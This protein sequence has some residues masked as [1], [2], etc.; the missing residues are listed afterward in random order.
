MFLEFYHALAKIACTHAPNGVVYHAMSYHITISGIEV[1]CDT[2]EEVMSLL[3]LSKPKGPGRPPKHGQPIRAIKEIADLHKT[4]KFLKLL[5]ECGQSGAAASQIVDRLSLNGARGIGGALV[6]VRKVLL[7]FNFNPSE[8]FKMIGFRSD[9][10]WKRGTKA[11]EA[12]I[13][14]EGSLVV[15]K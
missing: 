10:R 6:A 5:I 13:L 8:V 7:G 2:P 11:E 14:V 3:G 15:K 9:R 12:L 4:H 1:A